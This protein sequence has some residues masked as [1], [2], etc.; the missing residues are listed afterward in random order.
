MAHDDAVTPEAD[1]TG[2]E[3]KLFIHLLRLN[4]RQ[5]TNAELMRGS[6]VNHRA[7]FFRAKANLRERWSLTPGTTQVPL[8][9]LLSLTDGTTVSPV[10]PPV[11]PLE[12]VVSRAEPGQSHQGNHL[13]HG[14]NLPIDVEALLQK[15]RMMPSVTARLD[16]EVV[17]APEA[18]SSTPLTVSGEEAWVEEVDHRR[19]CMQA[20]LLDGSGEPNVR[21][22]PYNERRRAQVQALQN[23]FQAL[24]ARPLTV[25]AAKRW[26]VLADDSA[27]EA[28][29]TIEAAHLRLGAKAEHPIA[30]IAK[31]LANK[32][33]ERM[34]QPAPARAAAGDTRPASL[35]PASGGGEDN[36]Y[37]KEPTPE[38]KRKQERLRALGIRFAGDGLGPLAEE[39]DD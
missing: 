29:D 32:R 38:T 21:N 18:P 17:P 11:S 9:R 23:A 26:L 28:F 22:S 1:M 35:D 2:P 36:Y 20:D 19:S 24:F 7:T 12:P 39:D 31:V 5:A 30:Y 4:G 10:E 13:S 37:L 34:R 27:E 8:M 14:G 33:E 25:E 6:G 15:L 16:A 3:A